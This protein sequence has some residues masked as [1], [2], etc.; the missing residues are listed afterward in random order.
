MSAG[1][2][3]AGLLVAGTATAKTM[4]ERGK[5]D[6][7]EYVHGGV[8]KAALKKVEQIEDQY[9]LKAVFTNATGAYLAKVEVELTSSNGDRVLDVTTSG[10]VLLA[11]LPPG[12]YELEANVPGRD[13]VTHTFT[14]RGED[15]ARLYLQLEE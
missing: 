13:S 4:L 6:G 3:L 1:L 9:D 15:R 8:G 11:D 7:I 2:V 14:A 10:P 12:H 5:K